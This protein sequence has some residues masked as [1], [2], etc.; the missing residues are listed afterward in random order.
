MRGDVSELLPACYVRGWEPWVQKVFF[1]WLPPLALQSGRNQRENLVGWV[2]DFNLVADLIHT[3]MFSV[4]NFPGS[5]RDD[6][7]VGKLTFCST[8]ACGESAQ[9][10]KRGGRECDQPECCNGPPRQPSCPH[11]LPFGAAP[12]VDGRS[13]A[14]RSQWGLWLISLCEPLLRQRDT[15]TPGADHLPSVGGDTP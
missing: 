10:E 14:K 13:S 12:V 4:L 8:W 5:R 1:K 3:V 7:R 11:S 6:Q 9:Q 15:T 2:I